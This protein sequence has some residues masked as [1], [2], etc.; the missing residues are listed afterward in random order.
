MSRRALHLNLASLTLGAA[1]SV[2]AGFA[3]G[4]IAPLDA[5]VVWTVAVLAAALVQRWRA[6]GAGPFR[7]V[8]PTRL[9][10]VTG[11][12][13]AAGT[14]IFFAGLERLGPVPVALLGALAPVAGGAL[15]WLGLSERLAR[16]DLLL[17]AAAVAGAVLF[18]WRESAGGLGD[19]LGLF[20]VALSTLCYA[21][22]NLHARLAL[23]RGRPA[24]AVAAGAKVAALGFL[25]LGGLAAGALGQRAPDLAAVGWVAAGAVVGGWFALVLFYRALD[26]AGLARV[27]A[28][29]AAAPLATAAAAWPFFPVPLTPVNLAG[30]A[31]LAA[32]CL[33]LGL[34]PRA[35]GRIRP[36]RAPR[37][38]GRRWAPPG[39]RRSRKPA[40]GWRGPPR[41]PWPPPSRPGTPRST[42]CAG[43]RAG[44]R[45][46]GSP[47]AWPAP[48]PGAG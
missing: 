48:P 18:T 21:A 12:L 6:G 32:A 30:A 20:L 23:G 9:E 35:P 3:V 19:P 8:L 15:A 2:L 22:S 4:R 11:L 41:R 44:S 43:R 45:R 39:P 31:V 40:A 16:R 7:G 13:D 10:V 34:A 42:R 25:L 46:C 47:A 33:A 14:A 5:A 24:T 29:R 26:A 27:S 37:R 17:A 1:A 38:R 36:S 28:V